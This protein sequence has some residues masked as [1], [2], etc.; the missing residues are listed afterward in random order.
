[1]HRFF[2]SAKYEKKTVVPSLSP[3]MDIQVSSNFERFFYHI[4]E[5]NSHQVA[6]WM[7]VF[8][9]SGIL[10]VPKDIH[11]KARSIMASFSVTEEQTL[12]TI[13]RYKEKS[14]YLLCPH[15]A[16]GV[17][18]LEQKWKELTANATYPI[19]F[20]SLATASPAKFQDA[21]EKAL[22]YLCSLPA[23][24]ERILSLPSVCKTIDNDVLA[25]KKIIEENVVN[26]QPTED[27]TVGRRV[28]TVVP[29]S[30]ANLG[31]G[32]DVF[33]LAVGLYLTTEVEVVE[34]KD[35]DSIISITF[36]GEGKG[37]VP[38]DE[39]NFL[40]TSVVYVSRKEKKSIPVHVRFNF[41]IKNDIPL[42]RGLGSSGA[43]VVSGVLIANKLFHLGMNTSQILRYCLEIEGH[44][45]N[46]SASLCGGF[47]ACCS[48]SDENDGLSNVC[49]RK[50]PYSDRIKAVVAI[51]DFEVST[52]N[53]RQALP[54]TYSR[55]D[56]VFNLQ[57]VGLLATALSDDGIVEKSLVHEAMR[58]KIHQPFRMHLVP[59]LSACLELTPH[60]THG[61][62][63]VC[64][65]GSGSTIL[66]LCR[67]NFEHVE[68]QMGSLLK[69]AGIPCRTATLEICRGGSLVSEI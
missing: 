58:D 19:C 51:P 23:E 63:G 44:P 43:A 20:A 29:G 36:E 56:V 28:R 62:L 27:V 13:K 37:V 57:R 14:N 31:S 38:L 40:W 54:P 11:D 9:E 16:I 47:V 21:Q 35:G 52:E 3:S 66:A 64:L 12:S 32:F 69:R 61:L 67:D 60:N 10:D 25:L 50:L 15:S 68:E 53:A 6:Q 55:K 22:G 1:L 41:S 26:D 42:G 4:T 39:T 33:G 24:L 49:A 45:D 30:C 5:R 34:R 7:D 48:F 18:A 2:T 17:Y 59:G 65:S 8:N 46:A